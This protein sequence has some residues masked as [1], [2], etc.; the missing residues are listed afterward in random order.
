MSPPLI[1]GEYISRETL[2]I[3]YDVRIKIFGE[4]LTTSD[5]ADDTNSWVRAEDSRASY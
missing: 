1:Y 4:T 3:K 5:D 2:M